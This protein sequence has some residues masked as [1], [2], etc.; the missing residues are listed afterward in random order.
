MGLQSK[1]KPAIIADMGT[2]TSD[3]MMKSKMILS[4]RSS[5]AEEEDFNARREDDSGSRSSLQAS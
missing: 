1:A 3:F 2:T 4:P 5:D